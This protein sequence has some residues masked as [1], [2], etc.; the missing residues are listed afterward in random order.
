[1]TEINKSPKTLPPHTFKVK[2]AIPEHVQTVARILLKEGFMCYL[3][4]GALRDVVL[5]I[6][7]DDYDLATNALPEQML[8]IFPKAVSTGIRF[9][10]VTALIREKDGFPVYEVQITTFRSE[11]RY[12][13]GRWPSEVKF[14][15]DLDEDLK[16]RDFTFNSMAFD[17]SSGVLDGR[18]AVKEWEI[19]D[20]FGGRKDLSDKVVRAVGSPVERFTE[21]GLRSFKACRMASQLDFDIEPKTAEAITKTLSVAG[22]VSMERVRDEFIKMLKNSEKPSIGV[23]LMKDLGLLELFLPELLEG[24]GVEQKL[25]HKHDVYTHLLRTVD[26]APVDIRLA[27]LFHDIG[28]PRKAMPDGH[29]YGHDIEGEKMTKE[30]MKR[31]KFSGAETERTARL[32]KYHMFHYPVVDGDASKEEVEAYEAKKWTDAAVRRFMARVGEENID[33]LFELRIADATA[34]PNGAWQPA[35]LEHLQARISDVRQKDMA[36]KVTDLKISGNDLKK[37]GIDSGPRMGEILKKL[38]DKVIEDP[39][40]NEKSVLEK[41]AKGMVE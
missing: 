12:V 27:A 35:E 28:K 14:V 25:F 13:G 31:M 24:V 29:F 16:R 3:V 9:G 22:Q 17:F 21:D 19:Y 39:S 20:P 41:L 30:I 15:S 6:E 8:K 38:L 33:D 18:A 40:I 37:L 34:N 7:P 32:V 4:G 10:T 2:F 1:M 11:E 36:L 23:D 26:L 5:G